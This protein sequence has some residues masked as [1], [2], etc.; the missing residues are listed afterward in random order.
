MA[1]PVDAEEV[2]YLVI[3]VHK[4]T[5]QV[6][7]GIDESWAKAIDEA[8]DELLGKLEQVGGC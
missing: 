1:H 6:G 3:A 2:L 7:H 4:N 5:T 8:K